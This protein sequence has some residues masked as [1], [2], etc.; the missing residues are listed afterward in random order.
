M[1]EAGPSGSRRM[2]D[3]GL[4]ATG[5]LSLPWGFGRL[6]L[7]EAAAGGI[8]AKGDLSMDLEPLTKRVHVP[9]PPEAAFSLFTDGVGSWWPVDT[10]SLFGR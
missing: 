7:S 4:D 3:S 1:R 5:A 9:L 2:P 10:H 6:G 8:E